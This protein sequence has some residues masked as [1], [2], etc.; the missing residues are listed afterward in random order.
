MEPRCD[1]G[2]EA[3]NVTSRDARLD[4]QQHPPGASRSDPA[5]SGHPHNGHPCRDRTHAESRSRED[6]GYDGLCPSA[7]RPAFRGG[8]LRLG[9][10]YGAGECADGTLPPSTPAIRRTPALGHRRVDRRSD[11]QR[12]GGLHPLWGG[13]CKRLAQERL[14]AWPRTAY[15]SR[16]VT[17]SGLW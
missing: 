12:T 3:R 2:P 14:A 10:A 9:T 13:T 7:N 15:G 4:R 6:R 11:G 5:P 8:G 1:R 17:A 16:A